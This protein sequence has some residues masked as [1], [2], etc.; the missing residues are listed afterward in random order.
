MTP[1]PKKLG[2]LY[3]M[4]YLVNFTDFY[5]EADSEFNV[6]NISLDRGNKRLGMLWNAPETPVWNMFHW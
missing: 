6:L 1:I 5:F 2:Q 4:F 3:S